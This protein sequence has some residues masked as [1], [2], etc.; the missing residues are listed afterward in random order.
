MT[1]SDL[2]TGVTQR[3]ALAVLVAAVAGGGLGG[4]PGVLGVLAGGA[5]GLG[6]FRLLAARLSAVAPTGPALT[7]PW[8][9]LA[10][11]RLAIVTGV[12]AVLFVTGW[13]HPV[14]WLAGYTALPLAVVLQGLRLAREE[15]RA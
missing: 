15:S 13:A 5:L 8:P 12:A 3:T 14:A 2:T 11:L 6:S 1:A 9:V 10:G 4:T 7:A